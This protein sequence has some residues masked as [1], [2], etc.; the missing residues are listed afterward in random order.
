MHNFFARM[1]DALFVLYLTN[2]L[3]LSPALLGIV[4]ALTF[5]LLADRVLWAEQLTTWAA[6][7]LCR[8]VLAC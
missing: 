7:A 6:N 3:H 2:D 5:V 4:L 1:I 8:Y